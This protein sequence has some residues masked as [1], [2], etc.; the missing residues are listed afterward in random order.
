MLRSTY[1]H[2]RRIGA[3]TERRLWSEGV[4]DWEEFARRAP[5]KSQR[6]E[7]EASEL[8]LNRG[9]GAFFANRLP[10]SERWRIFRE[11]RDSAAFFDIETTGLDHRRDKITTIALFDG[12]KIRTYIR[13]ENLENFPTDVS[14]YKLLGSYNGKCFDAPFCEAEFPGL[15]LDQA[16]IDLRFVLR[17]LG[18][19]GG[20]KNCERLLGL[21]RTPGLEDID[22]FMAVQLWRLHEKGDPRALPALLRYNVEDVVNLRWIMETAYNLALSRLPL[23]SPQIH[24]SQKPEVNM[25][26]DP[27]II[28]EL[29]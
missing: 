18:Y 14:R 24:I 20:L 1:L 25:P 9:D 23:E 4:R 2:I 17:A 5:R 3:K 16:H 10:A 6:R 19:S 15:R 28:G 27:G 11:F 26:F 12:N 22:G 21:P 13:G 29:R 7:I 8:A